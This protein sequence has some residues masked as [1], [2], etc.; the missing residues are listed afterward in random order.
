MGIYP[1][2]K[3]SN[4]CSSEGLLYNMIS[5]DSPKLK[6]RDRPI[7]IFLHS[8]VSARAISKG[9]SVH[10]FRWSTYRLPFSSRPFAIDEEIEVV[11]LIWLTDNTA[12]KSSNSRL[13]VFRFPVLGQGVVVGILEVLDVISAIAILDNSQQQFFPP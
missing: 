6:H 9:G 13:K 11:S 2:S 5:L 8:L 3:A 1:I 10:C 12:W 4:C 7:V